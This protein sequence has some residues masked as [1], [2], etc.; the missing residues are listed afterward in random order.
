MINVNTW[1]VTRARRLYCII[2]FPIDEALIEGFN[3]YRTI[4]TPTTEVIV[5]N[6]T[7]NGGG[8][9][10]GS[11]HLFLVGVSPQPR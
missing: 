10:R 5:T 3:G 11:D 7:T 1:I 8:G 4:P 9:D 6:T 2:Q